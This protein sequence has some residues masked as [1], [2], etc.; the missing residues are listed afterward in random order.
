MYNLYD[1]TI[2]IFDTV[3]PQGHLKSVFKE[4]HVSRHKIRT[5]VVLDIIK[6]YVKYDMD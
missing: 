5:F 3:E 4:K 6:K 1:S 2:S